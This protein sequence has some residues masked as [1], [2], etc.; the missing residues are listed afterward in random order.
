MPGPIPPTSHPYAGAGSYLRAPGPF[1]A[2][3]PEREVGEPPGG[4]PCPGRAARGFPGR[5]AS[6]PRFLRPAPCPPIGLRRP[7]PHTR[8]SP[9]RPPGGASAGSGSVPVPS[10]PAVRGASDLSRRRPQR[11]GP[12]ATGGHTPAKRTPQGFPSLSE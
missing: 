5:R 12:A 2:P 9:G 6:P 11:L 8:R 4:R 1:A 3:A 10:V 7:A